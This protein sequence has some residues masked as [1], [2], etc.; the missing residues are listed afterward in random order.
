MNMYAD[1]I[2]NITFDKWEMPLVINMLTFSRETREKVIDEIKNIL[3]DKYYSYSDI[4][5]NDD[6]FKIA[7]DI[8]MQY[9]NE[10]EIDTVAEAVHNYLLKYEN[11][12]TTKA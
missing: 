3:G 7:L 6:V 2:V 11:L 10:K 12:L 4:S 5:F 1:V 8:E 9:Y